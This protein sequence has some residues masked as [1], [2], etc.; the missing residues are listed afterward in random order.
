[1]LNSS[2]IQITFYCYPAFPKD[3]NPCLT[4]SQA[5]KKICLTEP[6]LAGPKNMTKFQDSFHLALCNIKISNEGH[7]FI[8]HSESVNTNVSRILIGEF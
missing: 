8:L 6:K 5:S 2:T 7:F 3:E 1:L 4:F